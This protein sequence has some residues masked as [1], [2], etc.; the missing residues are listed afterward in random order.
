MLSVILFV[1]LRCFDEKSNFDHAWLSTG[2]C[3]MSECAYT[4]SIDIWI[5]VDFFFI[6]VM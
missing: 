4:L 5:V 1:V 2:R 6:G 3:R